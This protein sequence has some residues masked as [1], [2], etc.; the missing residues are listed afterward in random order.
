MLRFSLVF[1]GV[2]ALSF[3]SFFVALRHPATK[4]SVRCWIA[5]TFYDVTP[6]STPDDTPIVRAVRTTERVR[7]QCDAAD[8]P[9]IWVNRARPD[10]SYVLGTN[11][12][13]SVN[14][15]DL[16]GRLVSRADKLGAQNNVDI[17]AYQTSVLAASGD[18]DKSEIELFALDETTGALLKVQ[19]A[20]FKVASEE[21]L[22]GIC[23]YRAASA[24]YAITTDKSGLISQYLLSSENG[25]WSAALERQLRVETQPEGCVV[26][27]AQH[28]L[29]VG[30]EDVGIWA[31]DARPQAA[32]EG[33][34]IAE[35]EPVGVLAADVEGLAIYAPE[36][37]TGGFLVA[38]SQGNNTFV[39]FDRSPPHR[40]RGRFQV[41]TEEGFLGDTDGLDVTALPVGPEFPKGMLVV[42]DGLLHDPDG[43]RRKQRFAYVSW[44]E[45]EAQLGLT[46]QAE[47]AQRE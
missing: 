4:G 8:D 33:V 43:K 38:S 37:S 41:E 17:R 46:E 1:M 26:D 24:L 3:F 16:S 23:L 13:R 40:Y 36:N 7:D 21:E 10:Q 29:Y 27:D 22:Y 35:T 12:Q 45:I 11:K 19:G 15:Y 39:L 20:P 6:G 34:L 32:K 44:A 25:N 9:A 30:E 2:V 5:E 18:K 14:T 28:R 42:Q 31:F 47:S